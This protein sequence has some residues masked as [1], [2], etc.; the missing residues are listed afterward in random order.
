MPASQKLTL[1][2]EGNIST[3]KSSFLQLVRDM[4]GLQVS[5]PIGVLHVV[6]KM[7]FSNSLY[8]SIAYHL[9]RAFLRP[10][11]AGVEKGNNQLSMLCVGGA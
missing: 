5:G 4:Q 8:E 6:P 1:C 3:G 10:S 11:F 7:D 9:W 2:V